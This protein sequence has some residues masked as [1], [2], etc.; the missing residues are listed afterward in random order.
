MTQQ[1]KEDKDLEMAVFAAIIDRMDQNIGRVIQ[2]LEQA[3]E[4]E[5]TLILFFTD[6][7]SCPFDSNK[8]FIRKHDNASTTCIITSCFCI[9]SIGSI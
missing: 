3:N 6:N 9:T 2:K 8:N 1:E 4:L 7:G 5:N